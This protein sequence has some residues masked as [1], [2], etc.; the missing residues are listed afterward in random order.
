MS[1]IIGILAKEVSFYKDG[2]QSHEAKI[3]LT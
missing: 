1:P 3:S 2:S